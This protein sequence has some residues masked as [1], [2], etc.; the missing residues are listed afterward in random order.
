VVRGNSL[1]DIKDKFKRLKCEIRQWNIEVNS[2]NKT[3]KQE[4]V[5]Q[6]EELDKCDDEDSLQKEKR[7]LRVDLLS[8]SRSLEDKEAAMLK[9]KARVQWLKKEDSNSNYFHSKLRWRRARNDLVG[10]RIARSW[11]ED[12]HRVKSQAKWFFERRFEAP[13]VCKL[14]LDGVRFRSI[15]EADN[16]WLCNTITEA[17]VLEVV[18]QCDSSKCPGPDGF[19]FFFLKNNWEVIGKD[20]VMAI[21]YFHST[22]FISRGCN[23]SFITLVPKK[24]NPSDLNKFKPISLVGCVYNI[25]SKI[26]ANILKKVLPSVIDVNQSAF[27][28]GRRMLDNIL[29]ANETVDYLKNEKKSGVLVKVEF[30]KACDSVNWKFLYYM[31]GRLGFN[32]KWINWIKAC[33]ESASVSILVN[34]SPTEEFKPKRGLRQ[35]D[36]L[37]PFLFIIVVEGLSGLMRE[38][39]SASMFKGVEVGSQRVQVNLLQFADDTFFFC[40]PSYHNVLVIKAILRSFELVSGLRVNFH[41]STVGAVGISEID[42]IVYSKC[43]NSQQMDLPFKHLGIVIGEIP[44][45]VSFRSLL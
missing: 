8:Q 35:G 36:P 19:N 17:E 10:I 18:S 28:G 6:I 7:I 27:L 22:S 33:L 4:L 21:L 2:N 13:Q 29:V 12:P 32:V 16:A 25:L 20:V 15:S 26:L 38:A 31:L 11:C 5:A 39:K 37:A 1:E 44:K 3:R 41:K 43:L 24:D 23:A 40:N 14:N 45:G 42:K 34:G 30:E 9:Q